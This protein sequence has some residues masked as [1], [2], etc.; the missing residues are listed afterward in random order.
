[1]N[2]SEPTTNG[3]AGDRS[4]SDNLVQIRFFG[5][6]AAETFG[7]VEDVFG[8]TLERAPREL[9]GRP[10]YLRQAVL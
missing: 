4:A 5:Y 6:S 1:M 8:R 10:V 7:R 9:T 2:L 3:N